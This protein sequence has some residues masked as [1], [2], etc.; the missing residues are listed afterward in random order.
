M[1]IE[2]TRLIIDFIIDGYEVFKPRFQFTPA[3]VAEGLSIPENEAKTAIILIE[4][5]FRIA[6]LGEHDECIITE[7]NIKK[8]KTFR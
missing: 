6:M 5:Q 3:D 8:L 7:N 1:N 2:Q 4:K